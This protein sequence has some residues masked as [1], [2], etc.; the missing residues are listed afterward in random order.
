MDV[1]GLR[2][3]QVA[4]AAGFGFGG[5]APGGLAAN[6]EWRDDVRLLR[7]ARQ[8][9]APVLV[10]DRAYATAQ[11]L[12]PSP[13][14]D[15]GG[16]F[17]W[18]DGV[19]GT[20]RAGGFG[21]G[22]TPI[23]LAPDT[24]AGIPQPTDLAYG[25]D[26]ILYVAR[27]DGVVMTDRRDRF[28]DAR[29]DLAGFRAQRLAS[30]AG[31]GVWALDKVDGTLALLT[32]QPLR[33]E[34]FSPA[35]PQAFVPVEPNPRPPRLRLVKTARLP[36]GREG[37]AI[38]SSPGGRVAVLA[39]I[40]GEAAELYTLEGRTLARRFALEGLKFPYSLSWTGEDSIAVLA[41]DAATPGSP[42]PAG[43]AFVY[44]LEMPPSAT[45]TARPVGEVH[46]LLGIWDGGFVNALA[47]V[48]VY[49]V[50]DT[51]R[52]TPVSLRRL[53]AVSRATYARTGSVT[54][55]P[56]D[57]GQS[58][59]VWHRLQIEASIP[60][61]AG[62]RIWAHADE[63]GAVPPPPG[64]PGAPD[65]HPHLAG[66]A[67]TIPGAPIA[68]WC[69]TPSEFPFNPGLLACPAVPGKA[70]RFTVLMQRAGTR[71]RRVD[72]RYLYLHVEL[73]GD[74][75]AT[76]E[77]A[78][79][80]VYG[81][82]FSYRDRYLPGLYHERLAGPDAAAAG[83]ATPPDFLD[84]FLNIF[85][86]PFTEL[87]G[88]VA[89]SWLLTDPGATPE[90]AL[91]WLGGWIGIAPDTGSATGR[92][93]ERLR[94]APFTGRLHGTLGGLLAALELATGANVI[95]GGIIDPHGHAPR[96]GQ[97]ALAIN[98][99][100]ELPVLVLDTAGTGGTSTVL[101]GGA[102]TRGEIVAV[103]GYRLRRTFATILGA[104]LSDA[105]DPLT[106]GAT[107]SGNSFVGDTLILGDVA[108]REIAA[109]F[110]AQ[111]P[112]DRRDRRA[113]DTF[114]ARLAYQVMVLVRAS[115]RTMDLKRLRDIADAES[116][117]HVETTLSRAS[118]PLIVG[119]A[120]LVGIDSFLAPPPP[121]RAVRVGRTRIGGGDR[122]M[123]TGRLDQRGD[124]PA[125]AKPTAV[126]DAP[127]SIVSG[128]GFLL[129]AARSEAARGR[130]VAQSIWT[131]TN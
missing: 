95:T 47:D 49:P 23:A 96:P 81:S 39:W 3:W 100:S 12:K 37:I 108:R 24:P 111:M 48:A 65:W 86:A 127:G 131:W 44:A 20:L 75:L 109:L 128:A 105:D 63:G 101:A 22:A 16:S 11:A 126:A 2:C 27:N 125:T 99:D 67:A 80:R 117:A 71:V 98:G 33:R 29:V 35:D 38:A 88:Q 83:A 77:V 123:G 91:P 56:F 93:R 62:L 30:A 74:S 53:R 73:L 15:T 7:L 58:G 70:G 50:C 5:N 121:V 97:R 64:N 19:A 31:G 41:S 14:A 114:F 89:G 1:N 32:G 8:Q 43:Q 26:D 112:Q 115:P 13:V 9:D 102:V 34:G 4:D 130:T 129:S 72:G 118:R 66:A 45:A 18:W 106:L 87:E 40:L 78:A 79:I 113:V 36:E 69:D 122:V 84:R 90:P 104:N 17:A 110:S 52:D 57:S 68:S 54:L 92:L 107:P 120:S 25:T 119:A 60:D 85:E 103:E 59:A 124:G 10:E 6:L 116:P 46:P 51:R 28:A 61:H 82:R 94:A 55:G 76:P 21:D 42:A